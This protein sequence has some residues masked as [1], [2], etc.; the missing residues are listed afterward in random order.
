MTKDILK[1]ANFGD[2][3]ETKGK[4]VLLYRCEEKGCAHILVDVQDLKQRG[5]AYD[6]NGVLIYGLNDNYIITKKIY[7]CKKTEDD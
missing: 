4:H 7:E 6:D 3:F 2:L 1:D 5:L